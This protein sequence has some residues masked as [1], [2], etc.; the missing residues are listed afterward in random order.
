[1]SFTVKQRKCCFSGAAC[2]KLQRDFKGKC[3]FATKWIYYG[4]C[5]ETI[6]TV[7][8]CWRPDRLKGAKSEFSTIVQQQQRPIKSSRP[9]LLVEHQSPSIDAQRLQSPSKCFI[10]P[11]LF[12]QKVLLHIYAPHCDIIPHWQTDIWSQ[13]CVCYALKVISTFNY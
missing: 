12:K 1:M 2:S 5:C 13:K 3:V 10:S 4:V 7:Y 9:V 8:V 6:N 11:H